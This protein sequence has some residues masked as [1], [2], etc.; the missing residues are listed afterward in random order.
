MNPVLRSGLAALPV[1]PTPMKTISNFHHKILRGILKLSRV[2]PI[3]PLYFLL[4]EL[5]M[6]AFLHLDLLNLFWCIWSNPQTK[7]N[8][9][10]KYLLMMADSAS[11]T[12][13]A[14][15]RILFQIYALPDPLTLLSTQP[16]S[17]EKWKVLCKTAV[18]AWHEQSWRQKASANSKLTF[19]NVQTTGLTSR[20]HPVLRGIMTTHDVV[21]ARIHVKMLSGDYTCYSYLGND[22][23]QDSHCR[24]CLSLFPQYPPPE[25]D[26]IHLLTRC[27]ATSDTR[28]D[29]TPKILNEI[30]LHFL[31]NY[32]LAHPNQKDLT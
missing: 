3:A 20:P 11:L 17:K 30:S 24:L 19:L 28:A 1:R 22:R 14:H 21:R 15:L 8:A 23:H 6:E 18:T 10:T 32:T 7:A 29:L 5:P 31:G 16:W 13:T 4:G 25:E 27:R 9:I 26:M 2:S 12:W